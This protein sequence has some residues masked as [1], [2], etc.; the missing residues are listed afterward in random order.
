MIR[1]DEDPWRKNEIENTLEEISD[2]FS[3]HPSK[4]ASGTFNIF[5]PFDGKKNVLFH[6]SFNYNQL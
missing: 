3:G 4:K 2:I 5:A 6:V 1:K